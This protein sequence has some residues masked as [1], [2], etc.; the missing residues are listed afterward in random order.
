MLF[1]E[2]SIGYFE[3]WQKSEK[4]HRVFEILSEK[5]TVEQGKKQRNY[6]KGT[7]KPLKK[8]LLRR[9]NIIIIIFIIWKENIEGSKKMTRKPYRIR[10]RFWY[11]GAPPMRPLSLHKWCFKPCRNQWMKLLSG[12]IPVFKT[13]SK[14]EENPESQ[15]LSKIEITLLMHYDQFGPKMIQKSIFVKKR[16]KSWW[17]ESPTQAQSAKRVL[18]N[19][20][21]LLWFMPIIV[22]HFI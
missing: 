4:K 5:Y 22:Q 15:L 14:T 10:D 1:T 3:I 20:G 7:S 2:R 8:S 9:A 6:A 19:Y 17:F 16:N 11:S 18:W 13:S 12:G 21:Y